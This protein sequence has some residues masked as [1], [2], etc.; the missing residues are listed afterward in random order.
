MRRYAKGLE[1]ENVKD[2]LTRDPGF[3][4]ICLLLILYLMRMKRYVLMALVA[5]VMAGT[6]AG[7][8]SK[9][10]HGYVSKYPNHQRHPCEH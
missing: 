1:F 4:E 2:C 9:K 3:R 10:H 7:C 8:A 5:L 6:A